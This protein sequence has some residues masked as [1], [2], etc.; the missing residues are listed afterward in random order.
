MIKFT[1]TVLKPPH[2][3]GKVAR[4]NESRT[5][6]ED[7]H[8]QSKTKLK[9]IKRKMNGE[10]RRKNIRATKYATGSYFQELI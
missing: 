10:E 6:V 1:Y 8:A 5:F 7:L 3:I 2:T 9:K 4:P